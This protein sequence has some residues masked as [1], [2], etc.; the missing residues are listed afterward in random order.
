MPEKLLTALGAVGIGL[1]GCAALIGGSTLAGW[2][3]EATNEAGTITAGRFSAEYAGSSGFISWIGNTPVAW[4]SDVSKIDPVCGAGTHM[5]FRENLRIDIDGSDSNLR[6]AL[7]VFGQDQAFPRGGV[8]DA[9]SAELL[10]PDGKSLGVVDGSDIGAR[11]QHGSLPT[12]YSARWVISGKAGD[13]QMI[14]TWVVDCGSTDPRVDLP[15]RSFVL[16]QVV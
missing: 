5:T 8:T 12:D 13:Y 2:Y 3:A 10:D 4:G 15:P 7:A 9:L 1:L 16:E 11:P 6:A 14:W